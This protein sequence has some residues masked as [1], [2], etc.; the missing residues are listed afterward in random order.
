MG[1]TEKKAREI[2]DIVVATV[3]FDET[4]RT[5]IDGRK[6]GFCKLL[7]ERSTRK[8]VGCHVV[9][10][11]AVEIVQ[12]AAIAVSSGMRVEDLAQVPLSGVLARVSYRAISQLGVELRTGVPPDGSG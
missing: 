4:T 11:R 10:E 1:L 12:V 3:G 9:G 7:V 6:T 8:I 2:G 5:I